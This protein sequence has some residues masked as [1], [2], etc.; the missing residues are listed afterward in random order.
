MRQVSFMSEYLCYRRWG[1]HT[2]ACQDKVKR[3]MCP[4]NKGLNNIVRASITMS[5][6]KHDN[7]SHIHTMPGITA[8]TYTIISEYMRYKYNPNSPVNRKGL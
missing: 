1:R 4:V 2:Y 7:E 3:I 8:R 6:V 5:Q